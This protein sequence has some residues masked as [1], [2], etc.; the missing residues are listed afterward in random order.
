MQSETYQGSKLK[1]VLGGYFEQHFLTRWILPLLFLSYIGCLFIAWL[2]YPGFDWRV[3]YISNLG[4]PQDNPIGWIPWSIGHAV[5]ALLL[6]AMVSYIRRHL[7]ALNEKSL[8]R[9]SVLLYFGPIGL[10][11]LAI[12]PQ[13]PGLLIYIIHVV[14]AAL[15]LVGVNVA[16]WFI[17]P[18]LVQMKTLEK[19]PMIVV[20]FS[21]I[22][23]IC[24]IIAMMV[25]ISLYGTSPEV[26]Y[27]F[28]IAIWEWLMV[29]FDLFALSVLSLILPP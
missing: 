7:S 4:N 29:F 22:I 21:F 28:D 24:V 2:F 26:P 27:I 19:K 11:G 3:S 10:F 23:P 25:R 12:I 1:N 18:K 5:L 13:F 17:G 9:A 6:L 14:N 15:F 20:F 16:L 8:M